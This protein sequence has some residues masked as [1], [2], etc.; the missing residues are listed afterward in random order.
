MSDACLRCTR[1]KD[2][3][4]SLPKPVMKADACRVLYMHKYG[5]A[6]LS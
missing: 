4:D 6:R 1:F 2:T 5:G 3:Y